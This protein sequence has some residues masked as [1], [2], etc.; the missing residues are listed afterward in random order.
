M[1]VRSLLFSSGSI[2][3]AGA[4]GSGLFL[5]ASDLLYSR[6]RKRQP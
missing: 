3:P 6:L 1:A 4:G 2:P 5:G